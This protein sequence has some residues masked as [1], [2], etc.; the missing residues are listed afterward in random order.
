[1]KPL[2]AIDGE[3]LPPLVAGEALPKPVAPVTPKKPGTALYQPSPFNL[4]N[5]LH[6]EVLP[7][8]TL[9]DIVG[10]T[11]V[12]ADLWRH[13]DIEIDGHLIPQENWRLVKP[14]P[15]AIVNIRAIP[16]GKGG[17]SVLRTVMV[18]ALVVG[19]AVFAQWAAPAV[20]S[21]IG[22]GASATAIAA[23][24]A[25]ISTALTFVG[26]LIINA[27]IP[28][29][30][31]GAA[32][33]DPRYSL[34]GSSNAFQPWATVPRL[35][36]K[37][38]LYPMLAARPYT[39][40]FGDDQYIRMLLLVGFG[41]LRL[42][43]IRI[44][45][46]PLAA[47][48]GVEVEIHEG[49]PTG[50]GGNSTLTLFNRQ[51][52]EDNPNIP[53]S[54][55]IEST[56][57]TYPDTVEIN[58][59][60]SFPQGL[61]KF[62]KSGA[63]EDR[64]VD[65]AV[66]YRATGSA[67][68]WLEADWLENFDG[69]TGTDGRI[70]TKGRSLAVVRAT[71]RWAVPKGQYDVKLRRDTTVTGDNTVVDLVA[72]EALRSIRDDKPV[73][74]DGVTLI[75]LRM[76]ASE[77][78]NGVPNTVNCVAES[79]L[80][81]RDAAT[82]LWSYQITDSPAWAYAD[83]FRR[84]GPETMIADSRI[85]LNAIQSWATDCAATAP[86]AAEPRWTF[87][88]VLQGGSVFDGARKIASAGRGSFA[89]KD[90][91][92]SVIRD[93]PQTVPVQ[94]ITP[95]NSWGYEGSKRFV[96]IPHALRVRFT[97]ASK[98]YQSDEVVVYND[99]FN[100]GN[101][102]RYETIDV[103]GPL[104]S[105]AAWREGRYFLAVG[106]LRPEDHRITMD[107]ESLRCTM[108]DLV[109]FSHDVILV[110]L[111][112]ARV[113]GIATFG[114]TQID[115]LILDQEVQLEAG[116]AYSV[117]VRTRNGLS[118]VFAV[119]TYPG[120]GIVDRVYLTARPLLTIGVAVGDLV[121]F[122]ET[123]LETIP[124]IVRKVEPG[125]NL[126]ATL[127]LVEANP[128]IWTADSAAI[129][130]FDS[131]ITTQ[132]P[133]NQ[134]RPAV[135]FFS[136]RS[137]GT[138]SDNLGAGAVT[139]RLAVDIAP[140]ASSDYPVT[141]HEVQWR[142]AGGAGKW[143]S[144]G[145]AP[146]GQ[147]TIFVEPV[148]LGAGYDVRVRAISPYGVSSEWAVQTN[149]FVFGKVM[150]PDKPTALTVIGGYRSIAVDW[151]NPA[152]ADLSYVAVYESSSNS[153]GSAGL[154]AKVKGTSFVDTPVDPGATRYYWVVAVD[155]SENASDPNATG[156]TGTH[157][158]GLG[159]LEGFGD[160]GILTPDEKI[161]VIREWAQIVNE[162]S[163]LPALGTSFGLTAAVATYEANYNALGA[164]LSGITP[165]W[166]DDNT[167]SAIV[168]TDWNNAWLAYY[169]ARTQ[170]DGATKTKN[171]TT[172][173]WALVVGAQK[174]ENNATN[175]GDMIENFTGYASTADM[176]ASWNVAG[177]SGT[178]V[179]DAG[180][181]GGRC[182][183]LAGANCVATYNRL[184]AYNSE[185]LYEVSIRYYLNPPFA[186]GSYTYV[187][188]I[189]YDVSGAQL[190]GTDGGA[191]HYFASAVANGGE[192]FYTWTGY[193]R[194][195]AVMGTGAS[196]GVTA[197][198]PSNPH[199]CL[200]GTLSVQALILANYGGGAGGNTFVD[201]M[202]IRKVEDLV[203]L[204]ARPWSALALQQ[205]GQVVTYLGRSWIARVENTAQTPPSTG[206]GNTYWGLLS[207]KGADGLNGANGASSFAMTDVAWCGVYTPGT[208]TKVGGGN[209]WNGKARTTVAY[210]TGATFTFSAAPNIGGGLSRFASENESYATVDYWLHTSS[211]SNIYV[212]LRG[213]PY[214]PFGAWSAGVPMTVVCDNKT[215]Y[216]Y[217]GGTLIWYH[218]HYYVNQPL[219][220]DVAIYTAGDT[221]YGLG[222]SASGQQGIRGADG[223]PGGPGGPGRDAVVF[224]QDSAPGSPVEGDTWVTITQPAKWYKREGGVWVQLLGNMAG[225]N[226][227]TD[228]T[229]IADLIVG[230]AKIADL[231][232]GTLK[233]AGNAVTQSVAA[234][235]PTAY[236]L[237][238]GLAWTDIQTVTISADWG[239][240]VD[241]ISS[242]YAEFMSGSSSTIQMRLIRNGGVLFQTYA[243][244][245]QYVCP[246]FSDIPGAGTHTYAIQGVTTGIGNNV[247]V[248]ARYMRALLTRR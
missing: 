109:Q 236:S 96:D 131:K 183:A 86:N 35:F 170:L 3:V 61:V 47:F 8:S 136:L 168:R 51:V 83:L 235:T 140:A 182:M 151:T 50:W 60:I 24:A 209:A 105:T 211:D 212:Y 233:I 18:V 41:P 134:A 97:N 7:D 138:V 29:Q 79:Y 72:W 154:V 150:P 223:S 194:G 32:S 43:D 214:G 20:A 172:A 226:V 56:R 234:Y 44:G 204:P 221:M 68:A 106:Q 242:F 111:A 143:L 231:A 241:I 199:P 17:K 192:G 110:G 115:A 64:T 66:L 87:N 197:P 187:G 124:C 81:V 91:K 217:H 77:Q 157:A 179:S 38:R 237:Y 246:A 59:T 122:G 184:I 45:E 75:A 137:G 14:K 58:V 27:L 174:P 121:M 65:V 228:P 222:F 23:T 147:G 54:Y 178:L 71:G 53:L 213:A 98:N 12:K 107:I 177:G 198:D 62:N 26:M 112:Q 108:G 25:V 152:D 6:I 9:A 146:P 195:R 166:N 85:D 16:A 149:Y 39:E 141:W 114:A 207:D 127:T 180:M 218:E 34:T 193:F 55:G 5:P 63:K 219:Y 84:R 202:T 126:T 203:P 30:Y 135:P 57:T 69:T 165:A 240:V 148:R 1:M 175:S 167:S 244:T 191:H 74:Q 67:G 169:G 49:G 33:D 22:A 225:I 28:P 189:A 208:V 158:F 205:K 118:L 52:R 104:T 40:T 101:S 142:E 248:S 229:Y 42:S 155:T 11:G 21:A 4:A 160:D 129:P 161:K 224:R 216:Y 164:Y 227:I 73:L 188:I 139:N 95:R 89:L 185:D 120:P 159:E 102:S 153:F 48:T 230:T 88:G 243:W 119:T 181:G 210:A 130:A 123:A 90:G 186:A 46:T 238:P 100:A 31:S 36:G 15:G 37:W 190:Y 239:E 200:A 215:V 206:T 132:G 173:T 94:H 196:V 201:Y 80:P 116:K 2:D 232:V 128:A 19:V 93:V 13:L 162:H 163:T 125:A 10:K 117:R 70:R 82:G 144:T 176:L 92:Y 247:N 113:T 76:K 145:Q 78:L 99:G 171:S 133:P 103:D 220:G 245:P 156:G